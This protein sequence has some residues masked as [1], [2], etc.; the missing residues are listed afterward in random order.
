VC[1]AVG[2]VETCFD[3]GGQAKVTWGVGRGRLAP[4]GGILSGPGPPCCILS[5]EGPPFGIGWA[6]AASPPA[7][8]VATS[9]VP[10][11]VL[12]TVVVL[13][14]SPFTSKALLLPGL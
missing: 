4:P 7:V 2:A 3:E 13:S 5:R 12:D 6:A 11:P 9:W 10:P 8:L 14:V 1:W